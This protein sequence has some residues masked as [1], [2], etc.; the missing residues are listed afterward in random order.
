MWA[1]LE[2]EYMNLCTVFSQNID[3]IRFVSDRCVFNLL[4]L[5]LS[6]VRKFPNLGEFGSLEGEWR[7]QS[8]GQCRNK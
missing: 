4:F 3:Q 5:V 8:R 1:I 6:V 7:T 2:M